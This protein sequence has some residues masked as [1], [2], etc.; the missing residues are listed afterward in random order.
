M[1][2]AKKLKD[3]VAAL[4]KESK[5]LAAELADSQ[6]EAK[7]AVE[8]M[9]QLSLDKEALVQQQGKI[10]ATRFH[11]SLSFVLGPKVF[12]SKL[13]ESFLNLAL[14]V[15]TAL[16]ARKGFMDHLKDDKCPQGV[17]PE[18]WLEDDA[19]ILS[20]LLVVLDDPMKLFIEVMPSRTVCG[21]WTLL[22]GHRLALASDSEDDLIKQR[23]ALRLSQHDTMRLYVLA[24]D[25]VNAR[26]LR[27]L[28]K[29]T[30]SL[31]L[32]DR[33]VLWKK[34]IAAIDATAAGAKIHGSGS[35]AATRFATQL[36][37]TTAAA[38]KSVEAAEDLLTFSSVVAKEKKALNDV[39]QRM[40]TKA[41]SGAAVQQ[42]H[43]GLAQVQIQP[44]CATCG[45]RTHAGEVCNFDGTC[46]RCG[47]RGHQ[48]RIC[49]QKGQRLQ[50][51]QQQQQQRQ[52]QP[53]QQHGR[54]SYQQ[55]RQQQQQQQQP[56]QQQQQQQL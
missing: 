18:A 3:Q 10:P 51:Q 53:Q 19:Q 37:I 23:D 42:Q 8:G 46:N 34:L 55:Q 11:K 49:P 17:D 32:E 44:Q 48:S 6:S 4:T 5:R 38:A 1:S 24:H 20:A 31:A 45:S 43:I 47:E 41:S 12:N 14:V 50:Q 36:E 13:D 28:Q 7:T 54:Q 35:D 25:V 33:K 52:Q 26:L 56:R 22:E 16:G 15:T 39:W 9:Q 2:D 30:A 27:V 40:A 29:T 21:V